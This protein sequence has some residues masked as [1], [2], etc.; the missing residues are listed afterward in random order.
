M[1]RTC[2]VIKIA[3]NQLRKTDSCGTV[4]PDRVHDICLV[5][6]RNQDRQDN[7]ITRR[8][9]AVTPSLSRRKAS[10]PQQPTSLARSAE[11]QY[12][13]DDPASGRDCNAVV[14]GGRAGVPRLRVAPLQGQKCGPGWR[15]QALRRGRRCIRPAQRRSSGNI[16]ASRT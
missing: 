12:G 5:R 3:L 1:N 14:F 6:R 9:S 8:G 16:G 4:R 13:N 2:A 10:A 7:K 15:P 11:L